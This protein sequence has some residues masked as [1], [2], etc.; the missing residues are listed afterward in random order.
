[1]DKVAVFPLFLAA[2]A[3]FDG[4]SVLSSARNDME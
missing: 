4:R 2:E 1:M 3:A